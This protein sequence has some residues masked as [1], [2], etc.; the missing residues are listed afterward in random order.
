MNDP[1]WDTPLTAWPDALLG[2]ALPHTFISVDAE[3]AAIWA[4]RAAGQATQDGFSDGF[5][6]E[7][8][9]V[10]QDYPDGAHLKLDLCS[11]KQNGSV[12]RI[13]S[14]QEAFSLFDRPNMRVAAA[15][16]TMLRA[17]RDVHLALQPWQ[18][19]PRW[20]EFRIFVRDGRVVG[21]SQYHHKQAYPEIRTHLFD[22][23]TALADFCQKLLPSLHMPHVALDVFL[24]RQPEG[25]FS[26]VL[27]ELNPFVQRTDPCLFS[28]QQGGDFDGHLRHL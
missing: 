13:R 20:C 22:I 27:I 25:G 28:W 9:S 2:F 17:E 14:A 4:A 21:V 8:A 23:Q 19:I 5:S 12:P 24:K 18:D 1:L 26:V 10:L 3:D 16:G 11:L 15:L 7:L 6:E